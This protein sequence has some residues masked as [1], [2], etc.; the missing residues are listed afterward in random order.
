ML[1]PRGHTQKVKRMTILSIRAL[2]IIEREE[3][4]K[5]RIIDVRECY[6]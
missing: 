2:R 3:S 4:V 6:K 5:R 1:A